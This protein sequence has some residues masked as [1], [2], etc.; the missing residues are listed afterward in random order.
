MPPTATIE[1]NLLLLFGRTPDLAEFAPNPQ[2][3][4]PLL[5][6]CCHPGIPEEQ[7][8]PLI[9]HLLCGFNT[10]DIAR[11]IGLSE[12]L[13]S[14]RL[15]RAVTFFQRHPEALEPP[16]EALITLRADA[17]IEAIYQLFYKGFYATEAEA[18][19]RKQLLQETIA[20][21]RL[22]AENTLTR[23]PTAYA[24]L[25][26]MCF[27]S[28]RSE[29]RF[30]AMRELPGLA[31]AERSHW[32][33]NLIQN[34]VEALNLAAVG[35]ELSTYHLEA[36]VAYELASAPDFAH[37][38]WANVL[39]YY[40]WLCEFHPTPV[41]QLNRIFALLQLEG[42]DAALQALSALPGWEK[43]AAF[44]EVFGRL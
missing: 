31:T 41:Y 8:T 32:D 1:R 19:L 2:K 6:A 20:L 43:N 11:A 39:Q 16:D 26:W 38:N 21:G 13:L 3:R 22:L 33:Q 18:S 30:G 37:T 7:Q 29:N 10:A 12:D 9:L 24:L 42:P 44:F 14:R 25:A 17:V 40:Q 36:A 28:A 35:N 34:G 27:L 5:F 4:L 23:R 15:Q